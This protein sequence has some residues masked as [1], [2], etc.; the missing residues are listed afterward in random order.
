MGAWGLASARR[1]GV[2]RSEENRANTRLKTLHSNRFYLFIFTPLS[3]LWKI[4]LGLD[5]GREL[6]GRDICAL[7]MVPS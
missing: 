6:P 5:L 3:Q 2:G 1:Q 7:L 4:V